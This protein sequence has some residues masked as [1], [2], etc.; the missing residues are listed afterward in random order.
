MVYRDVAK[1]LALGTVVSLGRPTLKNIAERFAVYALLPE[2]PKRLRQMLHVQ[3]LKLTHWRRTAQVTIAVLVLLW[4]GVV[5]YRL[6]FP[7]AGQPPGSVSSGFQPVLPLPDKPSIVVLLLTNMSDDVKP[8]YLGDGI[9]EDITTNLSK[10]SGLFVISRSSAFTYKG[11]DVKV[12][13][14]SRELGVRYV[15]GGSVHRANDQ[16]RVT[17]QLIDATTGYHLWSERYDRPLKDLFALQDEMMRK[18]VVHLA[19]RLTE[20]EHGQLERTYAVN[21]KAYEL[22]QRALE[23]AFQGREGN[24]QARQLCEKAIELDPPPWE[25]SP[26]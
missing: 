23:L 2:P 6:L 21:L 20:V 8:D 22:R 5:T 17:A 1:K 11:K 24:A 19:P 16:V 3:R 13:E 10:L 18:I 26:G 15:L 9:V 12:R 7:T 4:V 14:V 25:W